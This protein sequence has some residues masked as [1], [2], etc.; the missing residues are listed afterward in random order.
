MVP[1]PLARSG[2]ATQPKT[3]PIA[4]LLPGVGSPS[5]PGFPMG[6]DTQCPDATADRGRSPTER[7][8]IM[9][10]SVSNSLI[11]RGVLALAVGI[12]ALVWP[13][14]TILALVILFAVFAF[15]DAGLS[16]ARAF[17]SDKAGSV[18]GYLLLSLIGLAA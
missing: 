3:A 7:N 5:R 1:L 4:V 12:I 6:V 11:L 16:A 18:V 17:S 9:L 2:P 10:K 14:V 15:M 13:N 8:T